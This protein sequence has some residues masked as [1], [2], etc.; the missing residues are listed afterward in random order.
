MPRR[1]VQSG[2][3]TLA[4]RQ[5]VVIDGIATCWPVAVGTSNQVAL[6]QRGGKAGKRMTPGQRTAGIKSRQACRAMARMV[7]QRQ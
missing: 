1:E 6:R 7:H 3:L 2:L 5:S 4:W